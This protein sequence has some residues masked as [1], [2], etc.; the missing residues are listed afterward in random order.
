MEVRDPLDPVEV[1]EVLLH[2]HAGDQES[3]HVVEP[4]LVGLTHQGRQLHVQLV[5]LRER[6]GD[7]E[8]GQVVEQRKVPRVTHGL[9]RRVRADDEVGGRDVES[10][11]RVE[12]RRVGDEPGCPSLECARRRSTQHRRRGLVGSNCHD[13][14]MMSE[15]PQVPDDAL[16]RLLVGAGSSYGNEI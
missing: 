11:E 8:V 16:Q 5:V 13:G 2:L 6:R 1:S 4:R 7:H 15:S 14:H 3:R 12:Q 9:C 10:S